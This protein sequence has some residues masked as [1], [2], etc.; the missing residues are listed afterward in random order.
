MPVT[1]LHKSILDAAARRMEA[2]EPP[3]SIVIEIGSATCENAAGA[4][5]VYAEFVRHIK[6]SG[7]DDII[8]RRTGCSGRCSR[9]PIVGVFAPGQMPVKYEQVTWRGVHDI[10]TRHVVGGEPVVDMMLDR[11]DEVVFRREYWFCATRQCES[12]DNADLM[13]GFTDKMAAAGV[14]M[15]RVAVRETDCLHLCDS[16]TAGDA[17]AHIALR[18]DRIIYAIHSY[19]DMDAIIAEHELGG[20][21]VERLMLHEKPVSDVFFSRYGNLPFFNMQTRV[22]LRNS[23]VIDPEDIDSY[24]LQDGYLALAKVLDKH[25][26]RWVI[27]QL[28]ESKLRGRGGGG[29]PTGLKWEQ[30]LNTPSDTR[31]VICNADE[32]DP[33][34]F[35][36]RSILEGDPF[37]VVE[38]MTIAG[39]TV[40]AQ[41]GFLYIRAEYPLA[42]SRVENALAQARALNLLGDNILG[43]G[44]SFDLEIRL[45]AG[46][47][48]CGEETALIAS[49]EGRRGQPRI[50]PP[51]PAQKG[52]FGKPTLIN[53]VESYVNIPVIFT[54]GPQWFSQIGTDKSGGTKVFALAG[55][56]KHTGLV[57]VPM[58]TSLQR[59]VFDIG[60]GSPEGKKIKAIQTGGPAGGCIRMDFMDLPV[61]FEALMELGS[62]MGSGGMIVLD[63]DDCMVDIAKF[64]LTFS[65]NESCGKCT[66]CREGTVRMLEI[67]ERITGGTGVPEDLDKL[68]RLALLMQRTSLC[69]LGRAAS[70]PVLSTLRYFREEYE[71]HVIDKRCPSRKCTALLRY[72]ILEDACIGCRLCA[73][74]CPV[75]CITGE[76]KKPHVIDQEACIRCGR[77][78]EVCKFSAITRD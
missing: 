22:A 72:T 46:A 74:E 49:I 7:R 31:Y 76:R 29:Y 18:P 26:Q 61:D 16:D 28:H 23:G 12:F 9:E 36:D 52:L 24:L 78:F 4:P 75:G 25:D 62:M 33:G 20:E 68:E 14:D 5:K 70:N 44:F 38:G 27:S 48:V 53:N 42:V 47:F 71:A 60:G 35:M 50:R 40:G 2:K 64:F 1:E 63:E 8:I 73:R 17:I 30:T 55:K 65:K 10:F 56:V 3:E 43:T 13:K 77:C 6:A 54:Y 37:A 34:A 66:S 51:F 59:I 32:G 58:G 41:K 19:E 45:G 69:G 21:P 39:F 57:E 67:L 15:T 11:T